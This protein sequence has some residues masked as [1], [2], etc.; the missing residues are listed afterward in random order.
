MSRQ[1]I[2]QI[3]GPQT[4]PDALKLFSIMGKK[5]AEP[6][7]KTGRGRGRGR[8]GGRAGAAPAQA[9]VDEAAVPEAPCEDL[10]AAPTPSESDGLWGAT[11][12]DL[13]DSLPSPGPLSVGGRALPS[14]AAVG[15]VDPTNTQ[16]FG[17]LHDCLNAVMMHP[18]FSDIQSQSPLPIR[19]GVPAY[20]SG[21]EAA[22]MIK[23]CVMKHKLTCVSSS[24]VLTCSQMIRRL[25][26]E[27]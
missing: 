5:A 25:C 13:T 19:S 1:V 16:H 10:A 18:L 26:H 12:G 8:G 15:A 23:E 21:H 11:L 22:G 17:W 9:A 20:E 2:P 14:T 6:K 27:L 4:P 24:H 7:A 3:L